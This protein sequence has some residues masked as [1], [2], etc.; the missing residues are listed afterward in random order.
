MPLNATYLSAEIQNELLNVTAEIIREQIAEEVNSAGLATIIV[1][2]SKDV[3]KKEQISICLRYA[4]YKEAEGHILHEEF[5]DFH[6]ADDLDAKSLS[7]QIVRE[8]GKL[9]LRKFDIVGQCYDGASVMS[10]HLSG[11]QARLKEHFPNAQY[12]H[13]HAHRLNLVLVDMCKNVSSAGEFFVLLEALYVFMTRSLVHKVFV[14]YQQRAKCRVKEL[15]RLSDTRWVCRYQSLSTLKTRYSYILEVL[16]HFCDSQESKRDPKLVVE[17]RG[18]LNQAMSVSFVTHLEVL[19]TLLSH[20]QA[21]SE[22]LQANDANLGNAVTMINSVI[23]IAEETRASGWPDLVQDI[24]RICEDNNIPTVPQPKRRRKQRTF[25]DSF[26]MASTGH[27]SQSEAESSAE[28][29]DDLR[30]NTFLP[31]LD[32]FKSEMTR[33]FSASNIAIM[34]G[35]DALLTPSSVNFLKFSAVEPFVELYTDSLDVDVQLL[36]AEMI[37]ARQN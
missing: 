6:E 19:M 26:L 9:G 35:V 14:D 7:N 8:V 37:M 33:R 10:G 4:E 34:Q 2:E 1:D 28:F 5:L 18:L 20:S 22:T 36:K 24:T 29:L 25:D 16:E 23:S 11:V 13:C 3:S 32:A 17:A 31:I 30:V 21:L 12:V 27:R 15:V